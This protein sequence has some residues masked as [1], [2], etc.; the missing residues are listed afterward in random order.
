MA[1]FHVEVERI[2][3]DPGVRAAKE[4]L[5]YRSDPEAQRLSE[6]IVAADKAFLDHPAIEALHSWFGISPFELDMLNLAVAVEI[7]PMLRRA[8]AYLNDNA[9]ATHPT[10]WLA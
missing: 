2:L 9:G 8:Y 5:F 10:Q 1:I 3:E 4:R 7:D 6:L